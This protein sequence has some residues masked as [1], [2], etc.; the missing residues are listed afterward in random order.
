MGCLHACADGSASGVQVLP[1]VFL[2]VGRSLNA[3]PSQLGTVTLCRAM[4]QVRADAVQL[5]TAHKTQD[6]R[7]GTPDHYIQLAVLQ[8]TAHLLSNAIV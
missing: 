2:F 7:A 6:P 1:A 5:V 4:V 3:S 8:L